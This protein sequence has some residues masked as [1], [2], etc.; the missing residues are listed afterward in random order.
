MREQ[1]PQARRGNKNVSA[2]QLHPNTNNSKHNFNLFLSILRHRIPLQGTYISH[3]YHFSFHSI[4]IAT[5]NLHRQSELIQLSNNDYIHPNK[6]QVVPQLQYN[7]NTPNT[8]VVPTPQSCSPMLCSSPYSTMLSMDS[9]N[10]SMTCFDDWSITKTL[11]GLSPL[12]HDPLDSCFPN[13]LPLSPLMELPCPTIQISHDHCDSTMPPI[14]PM[15]HESLLFPLPL[16]PLI[17]A[18]PVL[19]A[20]DSHFS[21]LDEYLD[22]LLV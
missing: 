11:G 15:Q 8:V 13:S 19:P 10:D 9:S 3:T 16:S 12:S 18:P 6:S 4:I 14:E 20:W 2:I 1:W 21:M 5:H 17:G 22:G 7:T